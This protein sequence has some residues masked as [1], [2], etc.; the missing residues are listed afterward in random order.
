MSMEQQFRTLINEIQSEGSKRKEQESSFRFE[1][2][3][4]QESLRKEYDLYKNH[5]SEL[6]DTI[7]GLIKTEVQSRSIEDQDLKRITA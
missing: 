4:V 6:M 1:I 2:K 3:K 5:Q 7:T